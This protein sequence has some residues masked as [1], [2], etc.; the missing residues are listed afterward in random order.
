[1]WLADREPFCADLGRTCSCRRLHNGIHVVLLR[2]ASSKSDWNITS[3]A[4]SVVFEN[5]NLH[6]ELF[7]VNKSLFALAAFEVMSPMVLQDVLF[8]NF[9]IESF[10]AARALSD[11]LRLAFQ[12]YLRK[13]ALQV[14]HDRLPWYINLSASITCKRALLMNFHNFFS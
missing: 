14:I 13:M 1:M 7:K 5:I 8:Q 3:S 2:N 9:D 12:I 10:V 6:S 11:N 4:F